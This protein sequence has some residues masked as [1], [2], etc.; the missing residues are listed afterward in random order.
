M[1]GGN[2]AYATHRNHVVFPD[3]HLFNPDRWTHPTPEMK[4]MFRAF[5]VGPRNCVGKNLARMQMI[6]HV[7]PCMT[8]EMIALSDTGAMHPVG[9]RLLGHALDGQAF[10]QRWKMTILSPDTIDLIHSYMPCRFNC[11]VLWR[12][13]VAPLIYM[14]SVFILR[15]AGDLPA[16]PLVLV[17]VKIPWWR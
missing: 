16:L 10:D 6:L 4:A 13:E 17:R 11:C 15:T 8:D 14:F 12:F 5:S 1:I 2:L 9:K 3:P 7:D